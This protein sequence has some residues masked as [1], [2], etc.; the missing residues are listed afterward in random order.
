M[1]KPQA[2]MS[3]QQHSATD[4]RQLPRIACTI[5]G[6]MVLSTVQPC[7]AEIQLKILFTSSFYRACPLQISPN[8]ISPIQASTRK[9]VVVVPGTASSDSPASLIAAVSIRSKVGPGHL[10][11]RAILFFQGSDSSFPTE[12]NQDNLLQSALPQCEHRI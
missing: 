4:G 10:E 7:S 3:M 9:V 2:Q 8:V 12:G 5:C 11:R 6:S 1:N